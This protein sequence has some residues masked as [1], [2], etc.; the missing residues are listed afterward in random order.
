MESFKKIDE[1]LPTAQKPKRPPAAR[2]PRIFVA[3]KTMVTIQSLLSS[4]R[5]KSPGIEI[6]E[7]RLLDWLVQ[8]QF[9]TLK[10]A[11]EKMLIQKYYSEE[12]FLERALE[13]IKRRTAQGEKYSLDDFKKDQKN[14]Q[15]KKKKMKENPKT[16]GLAKPNFTNENKA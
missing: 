11:F 3:E 8:E 7:T 13:E 4:L 1:K 15:S 12:T 9:S 10:P 5:E 6:N 2:R 16:V 14:R